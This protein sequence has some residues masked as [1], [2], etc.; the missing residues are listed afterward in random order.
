MSQD[1]QIG[2]HIH[3]RW[4]IKKIFRGG[5]GVVYVVYDHKLREAFAAK[6][7]QDEVS[8]RNPIVVSRFRREALAWVKLDV[9]QN[10]TRAHFVE[11][12]EDK[13]FIFLEF[14]TGG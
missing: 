7:F 3:D 1:W 8:A 9:H 6:T 4:E 2:E 5:L 11:M 10:V 12:I 14:I 13:P